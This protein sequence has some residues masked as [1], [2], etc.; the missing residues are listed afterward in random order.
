MIATHHAPHIPD[1]PW[2]AVDMDKAAKLLKGYGLTEKE[3]TDLFELMYGYS[4]LI[5]EAG[6]S[7]FGMT[8]EE[9]IAKAKA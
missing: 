9:A 8:E 4:R 7:H 6:L 5:D 1:S 2:L 3:K